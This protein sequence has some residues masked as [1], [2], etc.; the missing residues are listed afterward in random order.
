MNL[1]QLMRRKPKISASKSLPMKKTIRN[2]LWS[3]VMTT[4][5]VSSAQP[6]APK[7]AIAAVEASADLI[8]KFPAEGLGDAAGAAPQGQPDLQG[9]W[10][11][12]VSPAAPPRTK[13]EAPHPPAQAVNWILTITKSK[14]G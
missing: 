12:V 13:R 7:L 3:A 4:C 2:L 11:A 9:V 5:L 6:T 14:E 10:K 8:K 1:R